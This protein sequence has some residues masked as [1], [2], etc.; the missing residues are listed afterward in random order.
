M[1]ENHGSLSQAERSGDQAE[2]L[3]G[4]LLTEA[5]VQESGRDR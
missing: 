4:Q 2:V 3:S 5:Q 1:V